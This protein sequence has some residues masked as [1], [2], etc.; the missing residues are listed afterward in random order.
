MLGHLNGLVQ[1][2]RNSIA[3]ALELRLSCINPP[4]CRHSNDHDGL[5]PI[6]IYVQN[7]HLEG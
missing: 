2:R 1:E 4:I 3:N 5:I 7:L 6:Y